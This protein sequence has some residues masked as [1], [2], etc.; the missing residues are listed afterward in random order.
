MTKVPEALWLRRASARNPAA[1]AQSA[2]G[3]EDAAA[4]G[5]KLLQ[6]PVPLRSPNVG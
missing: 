1:T 6:A 5:T 3:A 4:I 2:L